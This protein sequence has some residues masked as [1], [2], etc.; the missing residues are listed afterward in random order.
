MIS[1]DDVYTT[2]IGRNSPSLMN[3]FHE[4]SGKTPWATKADTLEA[5]VV[6]GFTIDTQQNQGTYNTT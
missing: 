5:P 1:K 3:L 6:L 4:L 2:A